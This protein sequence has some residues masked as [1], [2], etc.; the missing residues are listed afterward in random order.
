MMKHKVLVCLTGVCLSL[1]STLAAAQVCQTDTIKPSTTPDQFIVNGDGTVT[2]ASTGLMWT[3]CSLG[4]VAGAEGCDNKTSSLSWTASLQATRGFNQNG[5]LGG[6][7][8]WRLPNIKELG[9]IVEFQCHSPAIDLTVFPDTPAGAYW[10][11]TPDARAKQAARAVFF[12]T[13]SD[14]T[15]DVSSQRYVRLV[16]T[17]TN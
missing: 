5:G 4:Q 8:D 3:Q 9:S 15:P 14:I 17:A 7:A 12:V 13:G 11:S 10:S 16:R 6:Y 2:D 1:A